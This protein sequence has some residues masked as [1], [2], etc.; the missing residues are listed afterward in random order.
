MS[1]GFPSK[2]ALEAALPLAQVRGQVIFFRKD[3]QAPGDFMIIGPGGIIVVRVK[4]TRQLHVTLSAVEIQQ[5]ETLALLR[6]ADLVSEILRELWLWC[7][8]GSMRF[9]RVENKSLVELDRHG[10]PTG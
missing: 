3:A 9:F 6:S 4:R 10:R 2:K 8:F 7:P 5:R 1:R